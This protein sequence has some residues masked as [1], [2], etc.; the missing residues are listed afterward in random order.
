[1]NGSADNTPLRWLHLSDLHLGAPG[2]SLWWQVHQEFKQSL[3]EKM[4]QIGP[5]DLILLTGDLTWRGGAKEFLLVDQFLGELL[6]WLRA[7][8]PDCNP[9]VIPVPGN[10]D[11]VRPG[12]DDFAYGVLDKWEKGAEDPHIAQILKILWNDK[13]PSIFAKPFANYQKWLKRTILPQLGREGVSCRQSHFPGDL[14]VHL[15]WPGRCPLTV[16]GLNST[17]LACRNDAKGR[18]EI[19]TEQLQALLSAGSRG[20]NPLQ[21]LDG[22]ANLLLMH[23]PLEWFSD[24]GKKQFLETLYTPERF[25][26]TLCGHRHT[27]LASHVAFSAGKPRCYIQTSSLFGLEHI[28]SNKERRSMG[29]T[30]G[31]LNADGQIRIWPLQRVVMGGGDA[32]F[33]HDNTFGKA[34]EQG[35]APCA[36]GQSSPSAPIDLTPWLT[37]L[38]ERTGSLEIRGIGSG[39]GRQR[40]AGK[41]PIESLYTPLRSRGGLDALGER[42]E[43]KTVTLAELLP[44]YQRLLIEG[45]PGAGKTTFLKLVAAMLAKDLLHMAHPQGKSWREEHLGMEGAARYPLFLRLSE[46]AILLAADNKPT[47][48]DRRRLLDLL[49]A[50]PNGRGDPRWRSHWEGLLQRGEAI[51]LLDGLDEVA[52][53]RVRTR[54]IQI[55]Q[56]ATRNWNNC[57]IIVTSRPFGV[58][59][60][61]GLGFHHGVIDP[62]GMEEIRTFIGRWSAALHASGDGEH[63]SGVAADHQQTLLQAIADR[64]TIRRLAANPVMLTCLCVVHWNEGKLPEGR[65]RV[66]QAVI[67]WLIGSRTTTRSAADYTDAFAEEAFATLALAMMKGGKG[68]KQAVFDKEEG[69][70][71]VAGLVSQHFQ[72][73]ATKPRQLE[74]ARQ[75]LAFECQGSGIVE[76][77]GD[78]RMK[79]WHLTFQEFLAALALAGMG[80]GEQQGEDWWPEVQPF[81]D[82]PQWQE[83]ITLLPG[84]LLDKGGRRRVDRLLERVLAMGGKKP[85]LPTEAR[86][87][88]IMG[89]LLEPMS[90]Y[91]YP[92]PQAIE[93]SHQA[94]LQRALA[95]FTREGAKRV[96]IQTRIAAAEALGQSGDP[97]LKGLNLIDV[98]NT[99]GWS[100]GKYLVTVTEYQAFVEQEGYQTQR[101]WCE[102]GWTRR[103]EKNWENPERWDDQ[104]LHPNR[105][106]VYVSWFE[107]MAY[108]R[109]LSERE[110]RTIRLPVETL[111]TKAAGQGTYPWGAA[112]PTPELANFDKNVGSPTPVGLYPSGDGP[113]GHCDLAGNVW[114]WQRNMYNDNEAM[115]T[116]TDPVVAAGD[117]PVWRGGSWLVPADVL[118]AAVRNGNPAEGRYVLLG[119]RVAAAPSS[120]L[121]S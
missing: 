20:E 42:E 82:N 96:P 56:D 45:Q 100:L 37:S 7:F 12:D 24:K 102:A 91:Q 54:V 27:N 28:G 16:V 13:K 80:D 53:E 120:T 105:P 47:A 14:L 114:E 98:P 101:W 11:L 121:D 61:K 62:F 52:D 29:Y 76:E 75:W 79:F 6:S 71:A 10:H 49:I 22:Q 59:Q 57:P 39:M 116:S 72:S 43:Q 50:S 65:A 93:E 115:N 32:S 25:L 38:L 41:Y 46:L 34:A 108:C 69:A 109:W 70:E 92:V 23:H 58:E 9:V 112:E 67:R 111:W 74:R 118:R 88:G 2:R 77:L 119:F 36:P 85:D 48:D 107:A 89:R 104:T 17:W 40:E 87:A 90:A 68:G 35:I 8:N 60:M 113:Q 30:W 86:I 81:L 78:R 97:R 94:V 51:L 83:S 106:V 117:T 63:D 26:A 110:Q 18:L 66:Y 84:T 55:V 44:R 4:A 99:G 15:T 5:P 1:M 73:F 21:G 31:Q 3:Q 103:L 95:L 19:A 33:L 64:L